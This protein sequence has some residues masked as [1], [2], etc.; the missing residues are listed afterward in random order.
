MPEVLSYH[1]LFGFKKMSLTDYVEMGRGI[2]LP[3]SVW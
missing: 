2:S 3:T 1:M